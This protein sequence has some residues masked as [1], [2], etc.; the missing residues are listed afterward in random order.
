MFFNS[1]G[2]T[3]QRNINGFN[4]LRKVPF[5]GAFCVVDCSHIRINGSLSDSS[6]LNRNHYHS[7][8][9]QGI[10]DFEGT[11]CISNVVTLYYNQK[12][13]LGIILYIYYITSFNIIYTCKS[14][15]LIIYFYF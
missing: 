5:L 10:Y 1:S 8:I 15:P 6:Y 3:A 14:L 12:I 11:Y 7:V 9:V 2:L 13:K 4:N